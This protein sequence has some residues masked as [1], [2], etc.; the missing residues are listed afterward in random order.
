[1]LDWAISL[2]SRYAADKYHLNKKNFFHASIKAVTLSRDPGGALYSQDLWND[3]APTLSQGR[4][5]CQWRPRIA[6]DSASKP[7]IKASTILTVGDQC[8]F[9]PFTHA[10]VSRYSLR[11]MVFSQQNHSN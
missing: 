5:C 8:F 6:G 1:L 2:I 11:F 4:R 9:S 10:V 3:R 7:K